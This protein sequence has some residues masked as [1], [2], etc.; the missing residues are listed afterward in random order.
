MAKLT[1]GKNLPKF[2]NFS[3]FDGKTLKLS[4]M[5]GD[6]FTLKDG[7]GT[8]MVF[9]GRS[10]ERTD[11]VVTGGTITSAKFYNSNGTLLYTFDNLSADAQ[12]IYKAFSFDKNPLRIVNGLLDGNDTVKG[13]AGNDTLWGFAGND[14]LIGGNGKDTLYGHAGNDTLTGGKGSDTFVFMVGYDQDT[15]TDF[16]RTGIDQDFIRMDYFLFDDIVYSETGGNV[17]LTL[18]TGD[19][20][21]LI[22]VTQAQIED[23]TKYFDFF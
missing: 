13:G 7:D 22:G 11:N 14:R 8:S 3:Q 12:S 5:D 16:T 15:V 9:T 18:P 1:Y 20:M 17:T 10:F 4:T 23:N 21:T 6:G 2:D 19:S